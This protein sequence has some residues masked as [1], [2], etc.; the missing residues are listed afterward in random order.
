MN[1]ELLNNEELVKYLESK[2]S[3][4]EETKA[5]MQ[6]GIDYYNYKQGIDDKKRA[7]IGKNGNLTTIKNLPNTI[8]KDNQY[9][10]ALD[11]KRSYVLS[12][13][14]NINS[15][16]KEAIDFLDGFI[17]NRFM[18]ALNKIAID[19][20][21]TAFGWMYLYTDGKDIKYK[22]LDP[23]T[24]IPEWSDDNH[25]SLDAVIRVVSESEFEAIELKV[26][27]YVYVYMLDGIKVFN[28]KDGKLTYLKDEQ[29][30]E[31]KGSLYSYK[32]LPFVYFKQ[33]N[34]ITLLDRIRCLQDALNL[35][36]SNYADNMFENPMNSILVLKNYEGEDLGEFREKL[37]Q[38]TAIK[39]RTADGS[40]GGVDTLEV[41]VN[42]ENYK[43][44]IELIKKAI[45]HNARSLY[46]DNERTNNAPNTLNIKAM[47]SDMELDANDL[48]LEFTASFE[49]LFSWIADI[50][51]IDFS[52]IEVKF[53]RSI[54]VND[55]STI[56]MI[57][58]S[59]GIISN[60]TL[61]AAHPFV[62]DVTEELKRIEKEK[63][64]V[65]DYYDDYKSLGGEGHDHLLGKENREDK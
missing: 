21:N 15:K 24:V 38:Y 11:Q 45:A 44:I 43:V 48:E 39:V 60:E 16:N 25:E 40:D 20:Y 41:T 58:N 34:E 30:L 5:K 23:M 54:M 65:L 13:R 46:L 33:P 18:R 6:T 28:Y 12:K 55:E 1:L 26:K 3:G 62:E 64:K 8:I 19:S 10:R 2:L 9:S 63:E 31:R 14:P 36:L 50:V 59:I 7:V 37:A 35:L 29:Y 51:G 4:F 56:E 61:V 47:Y 57:R 42:S 22:R 17:D 52:D 27:Y 32:K 49:Y 53:K